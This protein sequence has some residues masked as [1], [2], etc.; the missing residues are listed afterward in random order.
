M[1]YYDVLG[2]QVDCSPQDITK[3][4]R[5]LAKE[6]HPDRG[7]DQRRFH[8]ISEAYDVLKDPHKRAQFDFHNAN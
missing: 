2:L 4:Y 3:A 7:G 1:N 5:N 6:Y 8:E